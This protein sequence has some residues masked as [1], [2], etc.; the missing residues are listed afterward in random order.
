[1]EARALAT[2]SSQSADEA[3]RLSAKGAA[4]LA[5]LNNRKRSEIPATRTRRRRHFRKDAYLMEAAAVTTWRKSATG[6]VNSV[7]NQRLVTAIE[8]NSD[9]TAELTL[10][11]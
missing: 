11:D 9:L 4:R 2:P 5:R 6:L 10:V 8:P 3:I 1:M 7:A